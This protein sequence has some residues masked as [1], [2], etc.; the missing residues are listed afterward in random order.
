MPV[1]ELVYLTDQDENVQRVS[2]IGRAFMSESFNFIKKHSPTNII[3]ASG[4]TGF[5][6]C[7]IGKAVLYSE[8]GNNIM[9]WGGIGNDAPYSG[10][11]FPLFG[12]QREEIPITNFNALRVVA[13]TSGQ[14]VYLIGYL[15][16]AGTDL[17]NTLPVRPDNI[18]PFVISVSPVSGAT[19]VAQ[20][21]DVEIIFSEA[22][23]SSSLTSGAFRLTPAHNSILFVDS[24]NPAKA[25][26]SPNQN[27]SGGTTYIA[28]L[29]SGAV[30]DLVGNT[31]KS[32]ITWNFTV[33]GGLPPDT[34]APTVSSFSPVSGATNVAITTSPMVVFSEKMLSGTINTSGLYL[35]TI[36]GANRNTGRI[37]GTVSLNASDQKTV[38]L[39]PTTDLTEGTVY[40][41][42]VETL[43]KDLASNAKTSLE[44]APF[45]TSLTLDIVYTLTGGGSGT[46]YDGNDTRIGLKVDSSTSDIKGS[47]PKKA[48]F[49]LRN[50]G[51]SPTGTGTVRIRKGSDDSIAATL[52]TINVASLTGSYAD[53]TFENLSA[54]H[55]MATGDM[56]LFEWPGTGSSSDII[57]VNRYTG[58]AGPGA[59]Y[60]AYDGSYND[61][62]GK[63]VAGE[64]YA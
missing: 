41:I 42:T 50:G 26:L 47:I 38:T 30:T 18:D 34:T 19:G 21:A 15:N 10:H 7:P 16:G 39:D 22:I 17:E 63:G 12:G 40:Y 23:N 28:I 64:V 56:I 29:T 61:D 45:T 35:T 24:V 27:Y 46:M 32:G 8:S 25:V 11:G 2:T 33:S 53:Y 55:T 59:Y 20:N 9:W 37:A 31:C 43:C 36:S 3:S 52:G 54:N 58:S 13:Q 4:G 1:G 48:V 62:T 44:Q 49:R 57:E 60:T 14:I 6:S 5:D 51:G